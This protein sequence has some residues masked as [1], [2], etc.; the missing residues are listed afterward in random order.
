[1]VEKENSAMKIGNLSPNP[2]AK[3]RRKR[4]GRGGSSGYGG[5]SGRGTKGQKARSG[6]GVRRG[7]EGGQ[8]P[9]QRR[10]P[11][12]GFKR[13][14][15]VLED[16]AVVNVGMLNRFR[17]QSE[18]GMEQFAEEGLIPRKVVKVKILG[19]G[20]LKKALTV[21]AHKFSESAQKKI[22]TAGGKVE[23]I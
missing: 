16:W 3:K 7:F 18:V 4:V 22:E 19:D 1:M 20:E 21:R 15:K 10:L 23:V 13:P 5:T 11:S 2:K 12:R 8:M 17:A 9:L 14:V 6:G